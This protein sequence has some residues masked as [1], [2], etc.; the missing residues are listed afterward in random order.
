M[1]RQP[2][3]RRELAAALAQVGEAQDRVDEIVVGGR[4]R[5]R[6]RRLRETP[7][8]AP[9]RAASAAA[10]KRL[11][12]AAVVG[13][14]EDLL[15]GLRILHHEQAEVGQ[16]HLQRI[17]QP[18][19]DHLVA[20]RELA[21]RLRPA[22]T[23]DEVGDDEDERA[24]RH[25]LERRAEQLAQVRVAPSRA[26]RPATSCDAGC[27]ARGARPLRGGIMASTRVA[28]E[29]RADAVAMPREQARQHGD[30]IGRDA[31]ASSPRSEPKSTRAQVE[32]KPR[33]HFAIFVVLAHVRR[34]QPRSHVPV[35]VADIVVVLVLAQVGEVEAEAAK[36]RPV[37][38]VQQPVEPAYDRPLEPLQDELQDRCGRS[39]AD[40]AFRSGFSGAGTCAITRCTSWSAVSAFCERLVREHQAVAQHIRRE[41]DDVF[42]QH[43]VAPAQVG[44]ARAPPRSD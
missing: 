38:A 8:A 14:D 29:Q 21:E 6:P 7:R 22:G 15:P 26:L 23:A 27:A 1:L 31:R 36:Q 24:P 19:R 5:A 10:S 20:L 2:A 28:V 34:L 17:V 42:G 33:G 12:K 43:V 18:H 41:V 25:D 37:V 35:D 40:M 39:D 32:Q 13:V 44:R 9:S 11:R 16:L 4:A 3:A 30:E